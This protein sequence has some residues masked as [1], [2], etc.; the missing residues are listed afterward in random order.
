MKMNTVKIFCF[1]LIFQMLLA[2]SFPCRADT[3]VRNPALLLGSVPVLI[4]VIALLT[5][6][7]T[8]D[9]PPASGGENLPLNKKEILP[10]NAPLKVRSLL[11]APEDKFFTNYPVFLVSN[12]LLR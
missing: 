3:G 8:S 6:A 7:L 12:S 2:L 9:K 11:R 10:K 1:G 4:A 5:T